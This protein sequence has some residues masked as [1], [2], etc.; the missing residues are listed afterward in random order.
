MGWATDRWIRS[1][2]SA[3]T[4]YKGAMAAL[5]IGGIGCMFGMAYLDM[6]GLTIALFI[7]NVLL[8]IASPGY[9]AVAQIIAGPQ[10]TGRWVGVRTPLETQPDSSPCRSRGC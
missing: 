1:G 6:F 2:R 3:D 5:H 7:F 8:G 4:I 10:A 9:Y